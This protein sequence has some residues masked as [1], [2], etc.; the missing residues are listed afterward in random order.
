[1][2]FKIYEATRKK[3]KTMN[4]KISPL[5]KQEEDS[6]LYFS[7]FRRNGANKKRGIHLNFDEET[8]D[9]REE[10]NIFEAPR[11]FKSFNGTSYIA[12]NRDTNDDSAEF[13]HDG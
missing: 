9:Y 1:M 12:R 2:P 10:T 7:G 13:R 4:M 3:N 8:N 11:V 5:I 6:D